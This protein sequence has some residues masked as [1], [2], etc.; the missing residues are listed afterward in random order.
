VGIHYRYVLTL[1]LLLLFISNGYPIEPDSLLNQSF[2][3]CFNKALKFRNTNT[4]STIFYAKKALYFSKKNNEYGKEVDLFIFLIKAYKQK[5]EYASAIEKTQEAQHL[6]DKYSL[7]QKQAKLLMWKGNI[8]HSMGFS[9]KAL[10]LLFKASKTAPSS[11]INKE[12]LYYTGLVY[13][14]L[15]EIE[16]C[17][18]YTHQCLSTTAKKNNLTT[19]INAYIL[20]SNTYYKFDSINYYLNKAFQ[21]IENNPEMQ[22]KKVVVLNNQALL[23]DAVGKTEIRDKKYIEAIKIAKEK[24]F[25]SFLPELYNNYSYALMENKKFEEAKTLLDT[26]L[27]IAQQNKKLDVQ[28]SLL[29]TYSDLYK[30]SGDYSKSLEYLR[31]S[32]QKREAFRKQQQIQTSLFLSAVFETQK[33][34][35]EILLQE[36]RINRYN[37][38]ILIGA[39]IILL[40]VSALIYFRQ[41][42]SMEKISMENLEKEKSLEIADALIKGQDEERKRLAMDLHDGLGAKLGALKLKIDTN[43]SENPNYYDLTSTVDDISRNVRELSHRMLPARLAELGLIYSLK[44]L[45]L[46]V[47]ASSEMEIEFE[48]NIKTKL[49]D[50]I[51]I[52]LYYLIYELINNAIKH[53]KG[54][55]LTI[56]LFY[57]DESLTLSAEDDGVGFDVSAKGEGHGMNNIRQRIDYLNGTLII[58]SEKGQGSVFMIEI[59]MV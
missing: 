17:Q 6:I 33:K 12:I 3:S 20:L 43:L 7:N 18:N 41:K 19:D 49:D 48:T 45:I 59:P 37:I 53:S 34:E 38:Y 2:T 4:D 23:F 47:N 21:V 32:M 51:Q 9:S 27:I 24:Q 35:K 56:Q 42:M 29:D 5:G 57:A 30:E 46:S 15:E 26:S 22:Y 31:K 55:L 11:G 25:T 13:Y 14:G 8:Y 40:L 39:L 54:K 16:K 36:A 10:D 1:L 58:E 52:H 28:A 44:N 50:K